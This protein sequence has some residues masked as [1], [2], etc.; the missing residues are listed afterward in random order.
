M[1]TAQR[2]HGRLGASARSVASLLI[3]LAA[4][5]L[6]LAAVVYGAQPAATQLQ[7]RAPDQ[8]GVEASR[9]ATGHGNVQHSVEAHDEAPTGGGATT[10]TAKGAINLK[11]GTGEGQESPG[12]ESPTTGEESPATDEKSSA[13]GE[14]SPTTGE[15]S[16]ATDA[17]S[18]P[19]DEKSPAT[20]K[21]SS[22]TG[23]E[24]PATGEESPTTG[25]ESPA[26]DEKSP[27]TDEKS[28]PTDEKSPA[29]GKKSSATG[30]ESP[31]TDEKS[32]ATDEKSSPTDEKSPATDEKSSTTGEESPAT[33]EKSSTTDEKSSTTDEK[34]STTDEESST[35]DEESP[36]TGEESPTTGEESPTTGEESPASTTKAPPAPTAAPPTDDGAG[37]AVFFFLFCIVVVL[38]LVFYG[39]RLCPRVCP[40]FRRGNGSPGRGPHHPGSTSSSSQPSLA[41]QPYARLDGGAFYGDEEDYHC[42]APAHGVVVGRKM[43]RP[44]HP[45]PKA[46]AGDHFV[47]MTESPSYTVASRRAAPATTSPTTDAFNIMVDYNPA[48]MDE[49]L[50]PTAKPTAA[51]PAKTPPPLKNSLKSL[52]RGK[53]GPA[54]T[55]L[56]ATPTTTTTAAAAVTP[57]RA[58]SPL[59]HA[60]TDTHPSRGDS[61]SAPSRGTAPPANHGDWKWSDED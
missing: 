55:S 48:A 5:V 52:R 32:P 46:S 8:L 6:L 50:G 13:T 31:A 14:E 37:V 28:S 33:D 26:T 3:V 12:E 16:P 36:N 1:S 15:E 61:L 53:L 41:Q 58:A 7:G 29:T 51:V 18:S 25:E 17:K 60:T 24:S 43:S 39:G 23:E 35:T 45:P 27:A 47:E 57:A 59:A 34:S 38:G 4:F 56:T 44:A 54:S 19:T 2:R 20:G 11:A 9:T 40:L 49:L 21:K 22:A 30:E 10:A 42:R